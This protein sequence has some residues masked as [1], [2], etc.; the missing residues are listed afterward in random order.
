MFLSI[1]FAAVGVVGAIYSLAVAA[2]GL[3]NGPACRYRA[4]NGIE[5]WGRPF[6]N[7]YV[8]L[9]ETPVRGGFI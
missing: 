3:Q 2:V 9:P 7:R 8:V 1:G 5:I 4:D 6:I